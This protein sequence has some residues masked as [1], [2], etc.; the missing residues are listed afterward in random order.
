MIIRRANLHDI[1]SIN[2]LLKQVHKIHFEK[3]PDIFKPNTTKYTNQEL[4]DILCNNQTPVYVAVLDE[5]ICGYVFCEYKTIKDNTLLCDMKSLYIDD[6]CVDENCR[7]K[8]IGTSLY[9]YVKYVAKQN[10]CYRIDLNVWTLNNDAF[11]FYKKLG[12]TPLKTTME[13]IL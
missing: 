9:N 6:F 12:M 8:H 10:N 13:E 1:D 11:E 4:T 5:K 2:L 3:R 7:G